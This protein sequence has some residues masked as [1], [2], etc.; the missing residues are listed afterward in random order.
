M[1]TL[2]A[3][4]FSFFFLLNFF[5]RLSILYASDRSKIPEFQTKATG[6]LD[7][8]NLEAFLV[9]LCSYR[10]RPTSVV[11]PVYKLLSEHLTI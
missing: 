10:R 2:S 3:I 4:R 9:L 8:V 5:I 7:L 1:R 6:L 11:T